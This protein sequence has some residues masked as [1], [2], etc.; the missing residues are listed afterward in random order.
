[1][2]FCRARYSKEICE[3]CQEEYAL[4]AARERMCMEEK[5]VLTGTSYVQAVLMADYLDQHG[6]LA[7]CAVSP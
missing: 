4:F 1:M 5:R 2:Q 6:Q 7:H 3:L